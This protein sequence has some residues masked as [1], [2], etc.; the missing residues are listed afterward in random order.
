MKRLILP[1]VLFTIYSNLLSQKLEIDLAGVYQGTALFIQNPYTQKDGLF[2]IKDVYINNRRQELNYESSALILDFK[3][4]E[5]YT[6]VAIRIVSKDSL[7]KPI[8]L[9][10]D[11]ILFHTSYKFTS[12]SLT[13]SS[14]I[15][16]TEGERQAGTYI[17]ENLQGIYWQE[18]GRIKAMGKFE[19]AEYRFQPELVE[20]GNKYRIKYEF[21]NGWYLYS[22][23]MDYDYY[24][25][26][27]SFRPN[28]VR[29]IITLS[30]FSPF[31]IY[32][33]KSELVLSG[34]GNQ[35]DVTQLLPGNYVI[36]FNGKD[37]GAFTK[38]RR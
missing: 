29:D 2:C 9:N 14:L 3:G 16:T 15:W 4:H 31:E 33:Q 20:G 34:S 25:E 5:L 8:I 7:C 38:L 17:I 30:R 11:A 21:G 36:F 37:P 12:V 22:N 24:P 26:P 35:I 6:P 13:D 32:N 23:E 27:V 19:I 28:K 1:I 18:V 10:P